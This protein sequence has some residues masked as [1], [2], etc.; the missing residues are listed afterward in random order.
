MSESAQGVITLVFPEDY[1]RQL[2]SVA[3]VTS[4]NV[5]YLKRKFV[6]KAGWELVTFPLSEFASIE[7]KKEF[8]FSRVLFGALLV[9][10]ILFI[11]V[12]LVIYWNDLASGTRIQIG[13]L[14]LAGF[15]G[16]R[17]V[18]GARRHTFVFNRHQ[19]TKLIWRSLS[20]DDKLMQPLVDK[21]IEFTRAK[22]LLK[23]P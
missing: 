3:R 12:M 10:L 8:V 11:F 18:M 15:Y 9:A 19:G 7:Y 17:L 1:I 6:S 13:A 14:S 21:L 2:N 5:I 16:V 22:Q 20:G 4:E 23:N